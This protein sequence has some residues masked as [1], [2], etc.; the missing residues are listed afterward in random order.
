[1][2]AAATRSITCR[3][4]TRLRVS[5]NH[6][7]SNRIAS[8]FFTYFVHI[9]K[10]KILSC[11][12]APPSPR[13]C[14]HRQLPA[15]PFLRALLPARADPLRLRGQRAAAGK[16]APAPGRRPAPGPGPGHLKALQ[17]LIRTKSRHW[18]TKKNAYYRRNS[19]AS[20]GALMLS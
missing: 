11:N 13:V 15:G 9:S 12:P 16:P 19:G 2:A 8:D 4:L 18:D 3:R 5:G 1:M 10:N 7:L 20:S 6:R 17:Q 14:R